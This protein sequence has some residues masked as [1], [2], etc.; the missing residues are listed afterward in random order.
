MEKGQKGI[1]ILPIL[2]IIVLL[3]F[4][5][6]FIYHNIQLRKNNLNISSQTTVPS[7]STTP[8][9]PATKSIPTPIKG[10]N[11]EECYE[12]DKY[13]V[14]IEGFIGSAGSNFLVKYKTEDNQQF[15]CRYIIEENDFEIKNEW[16]EYFLGLENNFLL[17]DSGTGPPPRGLIIYNL[18]KKQKV[19]SGSYSLPTGIENN[20]IEFWKPVSIKVTKENCP[21]KDYIEGAGLGTGIEEHVRLELINL[22]ETS[23]NEY[24]CESRQ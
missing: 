7:I 11:L 9:L 10:T 5:G 20:Y 24:R 21:D 16:A 15:N 12:N 6:Y 22:N 1:V 3:G 13:Y 2:I 19:F 18:E 23:L 8:S 17:I 14:V 4:S